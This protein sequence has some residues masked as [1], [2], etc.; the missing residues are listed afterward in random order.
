MK[1]F[2]A[3]KMWL[4]DRLGLEVHPEKS[5][6]GNLKRHYTEFLGFK[7]KVRKKRKKKNGTAKYVV[8]ARVKEQTLLRI[9]EKSRFLIKQLRGTYD[10][11]R[12]YW[13]IQLYNTHLIGVH[14]YYSIAT[15][16][17]MCFQTIAFDVKKS[18][19]NR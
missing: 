19:Y 14:N 13:L 12:E 5:K 4:K 17:H 6:I 8:K 1:L 9:R 2:E 11:A 18:F 3:T 16:V 10:P 15:H 7:I